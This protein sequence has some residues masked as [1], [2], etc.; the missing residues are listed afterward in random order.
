M[1]LEASSVIRV[2]PQQHVVHAHCLTITP[3]AIRD[4][5]EQA[6]RIMGLDV[7]TSNSFGRRN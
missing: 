2:I 3:S 7:V 6:S 1:I 5:A 4:F